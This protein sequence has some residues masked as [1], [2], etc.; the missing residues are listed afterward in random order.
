MLTTHLQPHH[1]VTHIQHT[2]YSITQ[3]SSFISQSIYTCMYVWNPLRVRNGMRN[4]KK[5]RWNSINI[6]MCHVRDIKKVHYWFA[7]EKKKQERRKKGHCRVEIFL[8]FF[9][10]I[11]SL[12]SLVESNIHQLLW[13]WPFSHTHTSQSQSPLFSSHWCLTNKKKAIFFAHIQ[14]IF[15]HSRLFFLCVICACLYP[16]YPFAIIN[17]QFTSTHQQP[18]LTQLYLRRYGEKNA[19]PSFKDVDMWKERSFSF[20]FALLL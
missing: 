5:L 1:Q 20:F 17:R 16:S 9:F 2:Q 4:G 8:I 11:P 3:K 19:K 6:S 15:F 14:N 10:T 12:F 18:T 7:K 13:L